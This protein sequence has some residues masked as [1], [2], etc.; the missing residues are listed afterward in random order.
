M[1][2]KERI[3]QLEREVRRLKREINAMKALARR[4]TEEAT[5]H[6][7]GTAYDSRLVAWRFF[8]ILGHV[9]SMEVYDKVAHDVGKWRRATTH[10]DGEVRGSVSVS[11]VRRYLKEPLNE[12]DLEL[13]KNLEESA[14]EFL[15]EHSLRE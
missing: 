15:P 14:P 5:W 7:H 1:N 3:K 13:Q 6:R 12:H 9:R 4:Q 11:T 8:E 10:V 2:D